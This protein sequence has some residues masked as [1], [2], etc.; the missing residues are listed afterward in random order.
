MSLH[1]MNTNNS[2][3]NK[4]ISQNTYKQTGK[5]G[6]E[7]YTWSENTKE[8]I[9]QFSYQ[10]V[11]TNDEKLCSLAVIL[12]KILES[13][14]YELSVGHLLV[15]EYVEQMSILYKLIGYTRDI[16]DGK[17]EYMLAYMQIMVWYSHFPELAKYALKCFVYLDDKKT[18]PYGS[19][20]DI[21]YFC[22]YIR[23]ETKIMN[24][25]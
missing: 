21:K 2:E 12:D 15:T 20:K 24:I 14:Q 4:S 17:G 18:H 3:I 10:L 13:L 19:W 6:Q 25:H 23:K 16:V 22:N 1:Q 7:E 5:N 9:L 8:R 11:R